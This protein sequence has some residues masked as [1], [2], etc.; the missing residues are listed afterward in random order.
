ME[1]IFHDYMNGEYAYF[2]TKEKAEQFVEEYKNYWQQRINYEITEFDD[3]DL[4]PV[5]T[6]DP[7]I[8]EVF[9]EE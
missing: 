3:Y 4:V 9:G 7:A 2:T 5:Y 6:K 8:W 1:Y